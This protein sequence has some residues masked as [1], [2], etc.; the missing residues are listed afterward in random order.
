MWS[1]ARW[2]VLLETVC[3]DGG[4]AHS[5]HSS[6]RVSVLTQSKLRGCGTVGQNRVP[7]HCRLMQLGVRE[8]SRTAMVRMCVKLQTASPPCLPL[9]MADRLERVYHVADGL[10]AFQCGH[11]PGDVCTPPVNVLCLS[12]PA[13]IIESERLLRTLH[14]S[15]LVAED[16]RRVAFAG[17][18]RRI[19]PVCSLP[20]RLPVVHSL[21]VEDR[22]RVRRGAQARSATPIPPSLRAP[23]HRSRARV[24]APPLLRVDQV[25]VRPS[26]HPFGSRSGGAPS[27]KIQLARTTS[28]SRSAATADRLF[29][30]RV[31][32]EWRE[33]GLL[34]PTGDSAARLRFASSVHRGRAT[35]GGGD[36]R[37]A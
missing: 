2:L 8:H 9:E 11:A 22:S 37:G 28:N 15:A 3:H 31:R 7:A 36:K 4:T 1:I 10:Q 29:C 30:S 21:I 18:I 14:A 35:D 25:A 32:T 23:V 19:P 17:S 20:S 34:Q 27:G 16:S 6:S 24:P 5:V 13:W 12:Y 33:R 26:R